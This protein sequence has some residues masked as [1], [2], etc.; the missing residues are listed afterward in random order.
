MKKEWLQNNLFAPKISNLKLFDQIIYISIQIRE[1]EDA[2]S[3]PA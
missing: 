2:I 3:Y 1:T